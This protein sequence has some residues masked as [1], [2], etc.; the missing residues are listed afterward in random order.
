MKIIKKE[1]HKFF[2]VIYYYFHW[3]QEGSIG[4]CYKKRMQRMEML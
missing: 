4:I 1:S 2:I 3:V